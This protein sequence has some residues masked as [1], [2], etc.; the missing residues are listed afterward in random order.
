MNKQQLNCLVGRLRDPSNSGDGCKVLVLVLEAAD[1]IEAA[2][3]LEIRNANGLDPAEM[4]RLALLMEEL[5]ESVHMIGKVLRHGYE[6]G[7]PDYGQFTNRQHLVRELGQV[8]AILSLCE[9]RGDFTE[10]DLVRHAREKLAT[11]GQYLHHNHPQG[12][13]CG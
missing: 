5:A 10:E 12:V 8:W 3:G 13:T 6:S 4:E 1:A 7:H 9:A 11:V 2:D